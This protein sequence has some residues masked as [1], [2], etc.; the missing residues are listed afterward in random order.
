MCHPPQSCCAS[1]LIRTQPVPQVELP[2]EQLATVGDLVKV[3]EHA[4]S[5]WDF[6]GAEG[7]R[8]P[9]PDEMRELPPR[10]CKLRGER[11]LLPRVRVLF[12]CVC[13]FV[14]VYMFLSV[15]VYTLIYI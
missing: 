1:R 15:Y 6:Q 3:L 14:C 11:R 7:D 5:S 4:A 12:V 8:M 13:L 9:T 10:W 2:G